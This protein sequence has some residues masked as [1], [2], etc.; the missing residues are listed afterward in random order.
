MEPSGATGG[1]WSH[2]DRR[3][4]GSTGRSATGGNPRPRFRSVWKCELDYLETAAHE[5]SESRGLARVT[6]AQLNGGPVGPWLGLGWASEPKRKLLT[7]FSQVRSPI[8]SVRGG[9]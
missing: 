6:G 1:N 5:G 7:A 4:N 9:T 2:S 8:L 3:M